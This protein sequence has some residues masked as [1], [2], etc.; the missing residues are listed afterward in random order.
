MIWE[1]LSADTKEE[2]WFFYGALV[3]EAEIV[4]ESVRHLLLLLAT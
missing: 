2:S 4:I 1:Q 3:S